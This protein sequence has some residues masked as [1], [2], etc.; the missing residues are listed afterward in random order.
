MAISY[1]FHGPSRA[2]DGSGSF[3]NGLGPNV[4]NAVAVA[5]AAASDALAHTGWYR[6]VATSASLLQ[7]GASVTNG[8]NGEV[9]P[10]NHIE[11]RYLPA[12]HKIGVSAGA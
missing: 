12:G 3:A 9:W 8:A 4:G 10:A 1:T 11:A 5:D 2:R 6:I 7:Y